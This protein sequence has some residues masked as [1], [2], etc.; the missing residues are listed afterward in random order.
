ME[1]HACPQSPDLLVT[2][3]V[4][5]LIDVL[6]LGVVFADTEGRLLH[7]NTEAKRIW[8]ES[9]SVARTVEEYGQYV[10]WWAESGERVAPNEWS[11]SRALEG[12]TVVGQVFEIRRP[13]GARAT[14]VNSGAPLRDVDGNINGAIGVLQDI[15]EQSEAQRLSAAFIAIEAVLASALDDEEV[16]ERVL[17]MTTN[18]ISADSAVIYALRDGK[19]VVLRAYGHLKELIGQEFTDSEVLYSREAVRTQK[20]VAVSNAQLDEMVNHQLAERYGVRALIDAAVLIDGELAGDMTVHYNQIR[21]EFSSAEKTFVTEVGLSLGRAMATARV[22]KETATVADELQ[23]ALL[24][25]PASISGIRFSSSYRSAAD[26]ARVGGDFYDLMELPDGRVS[27]VLGDI[28]GKGLNAAKMMMMVKNSLRAYVFD[29]TE[30]DEVIAKAN[31]LLSANTEPHMFVTVFMGVLDPAT[32]DLRYCS[33]GHPPALIRR[34]DGSVTTLSNQSPMVGAFSAFE[35]TSS[36]EHLGQ[37][38]YLFLYT[39]GVIEANK[40]DEWFGESRL[41]DLV[42]QNASGEDACQAVVDAVAEFAGGKLDDDLALLVVS[43]GD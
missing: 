29:G 3:E 41:R 37:G 9:T 11:I 32:G 22:H 34:E 17:E 13:D 1:H 33:A 24:D 12:E 7:V 20:V 5:A 4:A 2:P 30:P 23:N 38:D 36:E 28:S 39:D 31:R 19:W 25:L 40:A 21:P 15:T 6:P 26:C 27:I 35:F 43:V 16:L 18:A 8:G 14:V 42:Q 10:A